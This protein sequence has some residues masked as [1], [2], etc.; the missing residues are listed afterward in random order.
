MVL[1]F[2]QNILSTPSWSRPKKKLTTKS[3]K[4][5]KGNTRNPSIN[6]KGRK[7]EIEFLGA[8]HAVRFFFVTFVLFVVKSSDQ[9]KNANVRISMLSRAGALG[10]LLGSSKAAW[11]DQRARPSLS[12]S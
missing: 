10:G 5:T 11:A 12:E 8:Q 9:S 7:S 4:V 6:R 3:T 2:C 1:R